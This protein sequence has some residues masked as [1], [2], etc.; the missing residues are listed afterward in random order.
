M[1]DDDLTIGLLWHSLNSDNLGVG[2]LTIGDMA[3]AEAAARGAGLRARYRVLG[4]ADP[5]PAYFQRENIEI[6]GL[7]ARDL[8]PIGGRLA[9]EARACDLVIDIG[10][11][12][13]F[14]DIYGPGRI[15]KMILAS[16]V[17]LRAGAPLIMAPQTIGPFKNPSISRAALGVMRRASLIATR[18]HLSSECAR[19]TGYAGP[20]IEASDVALR[21]PFRAPARRSEDVIRVGINV[22]G[23]LFSGGYSGRNM[24]GLKADYRRTMRRLAK[25]FTERRECE[26]HFISHVL[27]DDQPVEDDRRACMALHGEFPNSR[28]APAF[29]GPIEAKSYI[30]GM[31]FFVGA[32]MHACIAAFS[33][34]VPVV[35]VAYSRKFEGFFG[36]LGYDLVADARREDDEQIRAKVENAFE[37]RKSLHRSLRRAR[38]EGLRR[39]QPYEAALRGAI[40][41]A[42]RAGR[43]K[44][45]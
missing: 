41:E 39:L 10:A 25:A 32:R 11:G 12:D 24:F 22:S 13:S 16:N 40:A 42:A 7:R 19:R 17:V 4:W 3:I 34:G 44:A 9:R 45:A 28:V 43:S 35:P 21:L 29:R 1:A 18:D 2:A 33:A 38:A 15:S 36:A 23:L 37:R 26:V 30:A 27:S 6:A 5:K 14:S 20:L 8:N 31:D